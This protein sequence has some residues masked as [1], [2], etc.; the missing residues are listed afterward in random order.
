MYTGWFSPQQDKYPI[1]CIHAELLGTRCPTCGMAHGFSSILRGNIHEAIVFQKNSIPI[2]AFF[3]IQLLLRL[4][5]IILLVRS[6]GSLVLLANIDI[7]VSVLL[8]LFLFKDLVL[9]TFY[10]FYK[11]ILTGNTT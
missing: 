5:L 1:P 4:V 3:V 7:T 6:K 2:F 9:Q 11:M 8:F 10:I